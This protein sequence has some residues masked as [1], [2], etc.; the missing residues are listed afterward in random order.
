MNDQ[1]GIIGYGAMGSR[2]G[3]RVMGAGIPLAVY[4]INPA[5]LEQAHNDGAE[6]V[7]SVAELLARCSIVITM[8][9][10]SAHVESVVLGEGGI[11]VAAKPGTLLCDM[12]SSY[13][14]AT[15]CL[16]ALLKEKGIE[17][18]DAPVSGGTQGAEAGT[19]TVMVGGN[20]ALMERARPALEAIGTNVVHVGDI[21]CGHVVKALNNLLSAV[22]NAAAAEVTTLAVR[23]GISAETAIN[24]FATSSGRSR[25]TDFVYPNFVL[26]RSFNANFA[27]GLMKK[28]ADIATRLAREVDHPMLIGNLVR[29]IYGMAVSQFGPRADYT[30]IAQLY[31]GWTG[32]EMS[33]EG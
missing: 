16:H 30:R 1:V 28:D 33:K 19:L 3:R 13:P 25:V 22:T 23:N 8:L 10:E 4:D 21:G 18:I 31:E 26:T 20:P 2:M 5:T 6:P 27:L 11:L 15:R 24:I 12:S 14:P 9:P 29:D 7:K 17:M 32:V